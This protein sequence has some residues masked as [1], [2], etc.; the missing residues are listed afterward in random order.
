MDRYLDALRFCI[1]SEAKSYGFALVVW[2]TG[3]LEMIEAG[4]AVSSADVFAF[5]V[6]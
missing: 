3:T 2:S 6:A 1:S 4:G 5:I